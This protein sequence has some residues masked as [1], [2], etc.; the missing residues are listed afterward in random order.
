MTAPFS[1][2]GE[3]EDEGLVNIAHRSDLA[4]YFN[5]G[6]GCRDREKEGVREGEGEEGGEKT[7]RKEGEDG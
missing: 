4:L 1:F 5:Q 7:V 3:R 6:N 2:A